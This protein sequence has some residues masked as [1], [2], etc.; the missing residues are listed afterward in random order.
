M[1]VR[2]LSAVFVGIVLGGAG[3]APVLGA[4]ASGATVSASPAAPAPVPVTFPGAGELTDQL[5]AESA[6]RPLPPRLPA[7]AF[8][9]I[10]PIRE[11]LLAPDGQHYAARITVEG[12]EGLAVFSLTGAEKARFYALP[13][14]HELVRYF[15]AGNG[16]LLYSIGRTIVWD[17]DDAKTTRLVSL[18]LATGKHSFLG[19]PQE[20]GL[21][22][23]DV[24]WVDPEGKS[25]LLSYQPTIYEYPMVFRIDL[26]TGK[27][28]KVSP[29]YTDIWD[30]YADKAGTVRYGYGWTDSHHWQMVYRKTAAEPFKL[31]ARGTDRDDDQAWDASDKASQI[32]AG[33]EEGLILATNPAT[34]LKAIYRYNF[35]R[36]ERG[37]LVYEA[38]G[39]DIEAAFST[40]DGKSVRSAY[41]TDSRDRVKWWDP[42]LAELQAAFDKSVA[43]RLGEREVWIASRSRD[44]SMMLVNVLASND[45]GQW[46]VFQA[47]SGKMTKFIDDDSGLKTSQLAVS[48]YVRYQARDHT[49]L[50]AYL[51]LPPGRPTKNLPLIILPHGGPYGVRDRGDYNSDVQFLAN[52]GYVV[53]QPEYRGSGYYGKAFDDLGSGQWGRVM[54]DDIDDGMDWLIRR[55]VVDPKRVCLVGSSYG[56]YAALWGATRNPERYRCAASFAGVS[57]LPRQLK[58]QLSSDSNKASRERWRK[59]VQ[60]DETFDLRTVSP[61]FTLDKL[62]V[63]VMIV[64]GD[65]DQTVPPKQSRLYADALKARGLP[66]EYYELPGE[67]HG[68]HSTATAQVWYDKLDAFLSKYNPAQ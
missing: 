30:W 26:A 37:E 21:K 47:A 7:A 33:S 67:S 12:K 14:D 38:P 48:H 13:D 8:A 63:P 2:L 15:W 6:A 68:F 61:L 19:A 5:L 28:T 27:R 46:Y 58:Y 3:A 43:A 53:L 55:G 11:P 49:V 42:A 50:P 1:R 60:G 45:P 44:D 65:K 31:V 40:D 54:Q 17:G 52:R 24:L 36:H 56:G 18:D 62:T 9:R 51:T 34:G 35:A 29:S 59:K 10:S 16:R 41:Y 57:D 22:G 25:L 39:A 66:Y 23:D 4:P 64:H 20:M 32:E